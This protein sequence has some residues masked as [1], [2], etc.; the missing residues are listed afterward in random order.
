PRAVESNRSF[1]GPSSTSTRLILGD[2]VGAR[3]TWRTIPRDDC[4]STATPVPA[5][6]RRITSD[7]PVAIR[8]SVPLDTSE[9]PWRGSVPVALFPSYVGSAT[10]YVNVTGPTRSLGKA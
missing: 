6:R 7:P 1:P 3:Y 10:L 4:I 8:V 2:P 9:S 5:G